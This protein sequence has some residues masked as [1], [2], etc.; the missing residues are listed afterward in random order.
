M[1]DKKTI[2]LK[3]PSYSKQVYRLLSEKLYEV[4]DQESFDELKEK[5]Q[6]DFTFLES[7][8]E[9]NSASGKV[10]LLCAPKSY[11]KCF[12]GAVDAVIWPKMLEHEV[13]QTLLKRL[14]GENS[15]LGIESVYSRS[16]IDFKTFR[17]MDHLSMGHYADILAQSADQLGYSPLS[18]R[19]Y[20]DTIACFLSS[21]GNKLGLPYDVD[22]GVWRD[23]FVIQM[24]AT[25][26]DLVRPDFLK[27]MSDFSVTH[28]EQGL[29]KQAI[30]QVDAL[31]IFQLERSERVVLTAQWFHPDFKQKAQG[32]PS[33]LIHEVPSFEGIKPSFGQNTLMGPEKTAWTKVGGVTEA[34]EQAVQ[35]VQGM[36]F[37]DIYQMVNGDAVPEELDIEKIKALLGV[38]DDDILVRGSIEED[39]SFSRVKGSPEDLG[40]EASRVEGEGADE[41]ESSLT[42]KGQSEDLG[43]SAKE[44]TV[45]SGEELKNRAEELWRVKQ[46]EIIDNL[47][48]KQSVSGDESQNNLLPDE[49]VTAVIKDHL[50]L[51]DEEVSFVV[52]D[53]LSEGSSDKK[54]KQAVSSLSDQAK[55]QEIIKRDAQ[56]EKMR[57]LMTRMKQELVQKSNNQNGDS[58][59]AREGRQEERSEQAKD[60]KIESL[61]EELERQK[62]A[63]RQIRDSLQS[64]VNAKEEKLEKL[65]EKIEELQVEKQELKN[66]EK[67]ADLNELKKENESLIG[68]LE[69]SQK[70]V[71][72]MSERIE[73]EAGH[74]S[75]KDS[76]E[77]EKLRDLGKQA[78]SRIASMQIELVRAQKQVAEKESENL[79]LSKRIE[80]LETVDGPQDE[81]VDTKHLMDE[82]EALK[83]E[84]KSSS[85]REKNLGREL[86]KVE[87]KSRF[88]QAQLDSAQKKSGNGPSALSSSNQN[89]DRKVKQHERVIEVMKENE[90]RVQDDL[91]A[92]KDHIQKLKAEGMVLKNKVSELERK[93]QKYDKSAA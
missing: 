5:P 8:G 73:S 49:Q 92:K 87:Q 50:D 46:A 13:G 66:A 25:C 44:K 91:L 85:E 53:L 60:R 57:K 71:S 37:S 58:D 80:G 10:V 21:L 63:Q 41:K 89:V 27:A 32:H 78:Q 61:S 74:S 34:Y 7:T 43:E 23:V 6:V 51:K 88:L 59:L 81:T 16:E 62:S 56:I 39:E 15:S 65:T 9:I 54:D 2:L 14:L 11:Q 47:K 28:P 33:L 93:L 48:E 4:Y 1:K 75:S 42:V 19:T 35:N 18:I 86:K 82:I 77:I 38:T 22:Y 20:F 45:I 84:R 90:A 64:Q 40:E 76:K 79:S 70:R 31:D 29:L 26:Q 12:E 30:S 67:S 52:K 69:M 72:Q 36:S 24:H 55:D 3:C 17:F 83:E 68:Q